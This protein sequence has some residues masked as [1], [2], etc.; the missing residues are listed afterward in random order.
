MDSMLLLITAGLLT[1]GQ[2]YPA[3]KGN[4]DSRIDIPSTEEPPN[5]SGKSTFGKNSIADAIAQ[6][7]SLT[8]ISNTQQSTVVSG[9]NNSLSIRNCTCVKQY[10]C[11][12]TRYI[13]SVVDESKCNSPLEKCCEVQGV[14]SEDNLIVTTTQPLK[15]KSNCGV[16]TLRVGLKPVGNDEAS[17]YGEFPWMA[18][19]LQPKTLNGNFESMYVCG[20]SLI[21]PQ[22]V[23]TG[24]NFLHETDNLVVRLGEWDTQTTNELCPTQDVKVREVI[25]HENFSW[26]QANDIA[27]LILE[28]PV[29]MSVEN[30]GLIC[31]PEP[32]ENMDGRDCV[33]S[34]WGAVAKDW[35]IDIFHQGLDSD[36][37]DLAVRLRSA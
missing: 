29:D 7:S 3:D 11:N 6:N 18:T 14:L 19:V 17:T 25:I 34:G 32:N 9:S 37:T 26:I 10:L 36:V 16:S 8:P 1:L 31:L 22:V 2:G 35:T 5:S 30:V 21:H 33:A 27:M 20:G 15:S 24:G 28:R 23:L 13:N 12:S 4:T